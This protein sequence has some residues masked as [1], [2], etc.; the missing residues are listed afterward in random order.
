MIIRTGYSL[1]YLDSPDVVIQNTSKCLQA[2]TD[3]LYILRRTVIHDKQLVL[4]GRSGIRAIRIGC[5]SLNHTDRFI[6]DSMT[7]LEV[8]QIG[9]N[10]F[11]SPT[12][13]NP[14]LLI[15]NCSK[16]ASVEIGSKSFVSRGSLSITNCPLLSSLTIGSSSFTSYSTFELT[17]LP[18]LQSIHI[19]ENSFYSLLTFN[20][21]G[22]CF[23]AL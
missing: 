8:V 6:L 4:N 5:G 17:D 13:S 7:D 12:I 23:V 16:L 3:T 22:Q 15:T 20:L 9:S 1:E 10:V 14:I 2:T 19:G 11:R 18:N 21:T